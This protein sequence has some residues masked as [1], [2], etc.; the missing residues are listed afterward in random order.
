MYEYTTKHSFSN[1]IM[2]TNI[3]IQVFQC[4][5][6]CTFF[7]IF[8]K[9][10]NFLICDISIPINL[11][12]RGFQLAS[13]ERFFPCDK[14]VVRNRTA[15]AH[16]F[17]FIFITFYSLG[18]CYASNKYI[19]QGFHPINYALISNNLFHQKK[20]R[21]QIISRILCVFVF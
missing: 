6:F 5:C 10:C 11:F 7:N 1:Q 14:C 13:K 9:K 21:G 2:I 15:N 12:I 8:P 20:Y 3:F 17:P 16:M 19:E 4:S 18:Y